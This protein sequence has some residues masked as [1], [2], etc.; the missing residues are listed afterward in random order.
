MLCIVL[1]K[2]HVNILVSSSNFY[3]RMKGMNL[4]FKKD[5][6]KIKFEQ[7]NMEEFT[8]NMKLPHCH[9]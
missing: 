6:W 3:K 7:S 4:E 2:L 1:D 8:Y 9:T 5:R